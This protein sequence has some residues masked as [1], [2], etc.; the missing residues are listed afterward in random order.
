MGK[1]QSILTDSNEPDSATRVEGAVV[2]WDDV[3]RAQE[4]EINPN[5]IGQSKALAQGDIKQF[6]ELATG[7]SNFNPL[8]LED[9]EN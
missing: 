5:L 3:E 8:E 6:N 7:E 9:S 4:E 1:E 2:S